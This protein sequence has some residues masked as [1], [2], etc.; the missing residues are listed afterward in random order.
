MGGTAGDD[1]GRKCE[2]RAEEELGLWK[3]RESPELEWLGRRLEGIRRRD[4]SFWCMHGLIFVAMFAGMM[5]RPVV[6]IWGLVGALGIAAALI[7]PL[8]RW[9]RSRV[10]SEFVEAF[11]ENGICAGC[12]YSLE[13][14]GE[15]GDGCVVCAECGAAWRA[16]RI[17]RFMSPPRGNAE[18]MGFFRRFFG[19]R[20]SAY[21][22][23]DAGGHYRPIVREHEL[24][25]MSAT[26]G[27]IEHRRRLAQRELRSMGR[28]RRLLVAGLAGTLYL[29]VLVGA[30]RYGG[31]RI[32]GGTSPS[33]DTIGAMAMSLLSVIV[34]GLM[35]VLVPRALYRGGVGRSASR[36]RD[37]LLHLGLCASC[38]HDMSGCGSESD[39]S[40]VCPEC[41]AAWRFGRE[42]AGVVGDR[43]G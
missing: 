33:L 30:L 11:V 4:A 8:Q 40:V 17:R 18:D 10:W 21:G 7:M 22:I 35:F 6:G 34:F 39:G 16:E 25:A 42:E 9:N 19:R 32:S 23:V 2:I 14:L 15:Q 43:V 24:R 27:D 29:F 12:G 37:T 26:G 36:A 20:A 3:I 31:T 28:G 13:H 5:L 41:G 1:R 38:A